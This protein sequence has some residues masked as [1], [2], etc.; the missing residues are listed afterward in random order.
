[1]TTSRGKT[2]ADKF[3]RGNDFNEATKADYDAREVRLDNGKFVD[4]Y[5][6]G[7]EIVS[8][9]STQ[10]AD[11]PADAAEEYFNEFLDEYGRG[12]VVS[13]TTANRLHYPDL[14]GKP[15]QGDPILEVPV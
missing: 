6:P 14:V 10:L 15:L 9:K 7:E 4:G 12:N 11:I 8:R 5:T 3:Q 13:G 1:M 2:R